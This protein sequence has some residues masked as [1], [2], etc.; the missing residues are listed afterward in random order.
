MRSALTIL[1]CLLIL[2]CATLPPGYRVVKITDEKDGTHVVT[3]RR[4][5][6]FKMIRVDCLPD[7]VRVGKWIKLPE[8]REQ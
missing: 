7:S 2:S 3:M 6:V 5:Y 1:S 8:Q 4:A